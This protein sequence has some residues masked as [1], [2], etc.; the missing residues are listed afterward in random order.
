MPLVR[1]LAASCSKL[2]GMTAVHSGEHTHGIRSLEE[3]QARDLVGAV[4]CL[5]LWRAS[6]NR[7]TR[8]PSMVSSRGEMGL[9]TTSRILAW[10]LL[11]HL[12]GHCVEV[13]RERSGIYPRR[14]WRR[15]SAF[16][17][18]LHRKITSLG[19][20]A[21]LPPTWVG[22]T[23]GSRGNSQ[24]Q[25]CK[26][27]TARSDGRS[28]GTPSSIPHL[29]TPLLQPGATLVGGYRAGAQS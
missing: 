19:L 26:A 10:A 29:S 18:L 21:G 5:S 2:Y 8:S 25:Y 17:G 9:K 3:L 28:E 1:R 12:F 11:L 7:R 14:Y 6:R 20:G 15:K 27:S 4:G 13:S 23:S 16:G 22:S 24:E